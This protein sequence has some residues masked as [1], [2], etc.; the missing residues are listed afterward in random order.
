MVIPPR[1]TLCRLHFSLF[2]PDKCHQRQPTFP[3]YQREHFI[4]QSGE[5]LLNV[6]LQAHFTVCFEVCLHT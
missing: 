2:S 3:F 5:N 4:N 6:T 1:H